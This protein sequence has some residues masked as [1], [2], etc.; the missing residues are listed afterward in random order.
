MGTGGQYGFNDE[1]NSA[2]DDGKGNDKDTYGVRILIIV[3]SLGRLGSTDSL[4]DKRDDILCGGRS[5]TE[6]RSERAGASA[7]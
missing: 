1:Q 5:A 3:H 4:N 2:A 6:R 7:Q